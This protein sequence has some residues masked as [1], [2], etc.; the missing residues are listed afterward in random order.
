M[1]KAFYERDSRCDG[2]FYI[3]VKT[4]GIFCRITCTAKKPKRENVEFFKSAKQA[5]DEGYRPCKICN[6][7]EAR[8][9]TPEWVTII[10]EA[11]NKNP[12]ARI[13]DR[14][15]KNYGVNP[16]RLRRWFKA[17]HG[18]TLQAYL[19]ALRIGEAFGR[20][21]L[22]DAVIDAAYDSGYESLSGFNDAFKKI[23][24]STPKKCDMAEV[25]KTTRI[26][27]PLGPMLAGATDEGI[28]LLEFIDRRMIETQI[29]R[30][31]TRLR[32]RFTPGINPH[33]IRLQYEIDQYFSGARKQFSVPLAAAGTEFQQKVWRMLQRL[34]YGKT[35]SYKELAQMLSSPRSVRAVAGAN[36]DNM[37]ALLIPCHRVIGSDGNLTGYGGGLRRK[38]YLLDLERSKMNQ[39]N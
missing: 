21:K 11:V 9:K 18:M 26:T 17:N 36:G 34:P 14:D 29:K 1:E 30:L 5:L 23:F 2:L 28:C 25:I 35:I 7:M 16:A 27:T 33:L 6:P 10:L 4:T 19:R 32:A 37:I 24:D 39:S 20:I 3:G 8:G 15:I 12:A 13:K 38:K 31:S 22:G